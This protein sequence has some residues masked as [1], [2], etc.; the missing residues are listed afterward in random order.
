MTILPF[1]D[2]GWFLALSGSFARN[3]LSYSKKHFDKPLETCRVDNS[4]LDAEP[5]ASSEFNLDF[6]VNPTVDTQNSGVAA[7]ISRVM[8]AT[9]FVV[10]GA[11]AVL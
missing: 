1:F 8:S 5:A 7:S 10:A 6:G 3:A 9:A 4:F 11:F 2:H